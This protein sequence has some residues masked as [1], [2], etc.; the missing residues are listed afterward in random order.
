MSCCRNRRKTIELTVNTFHRRMV[1]S[2]D[3]EAIV[4]ASGLQEMVDTPAK[5]PSNVWISFPD[6]VSQTLIAPS[7]PTPLSVPPCQASQSQHTTTSNHRRARREPHSRNPQQM[8]PKQILLPIIQL[9]RLWRRRRRRRRHRRRRTI[10][11][12]PF[13]IIFRIFNRRIPVL[14]ILILV[15]VL[16]IVPRRRLLLHAHVRV[17]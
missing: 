1:L 12:P 5:W 14:L 4:A 2:S 15:L 10:L 13:R 7:A 3:P 9:I 17:M 11:I 16:V 6:N 8:P